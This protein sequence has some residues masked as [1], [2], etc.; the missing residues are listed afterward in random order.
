M[1]LKPYTIT[2]AQTLLS[3]AIAE[4]QPRHRVWRR[5]EHLYATGSDVEPTSTATSAG[6]VKQAPVEINTGVVNQALPHLN[7]IIGQVSDQ[8]PS[9]GATT[10]GYGDG[11]NDEL[12]REVARVAEALADHWF[13]LGGG[14]EALGLAAKDL[15]VLGP[16][17]IKV[18][19]RFSDEE[20]DKDVDEVENDIIALLEASEDLDPD[21]AADRVALTKRVTTEAGVFIEHVSPYDLF[22]DPNAT[23]L[24]DADWVAHRIVKPHDQLLEE[25]ELPADTTLT[26][27]AS[28]TT[29]AGHTSLGTAI[30][31][32]VLMEFAP[33]EVFEFYDLRTFRMTVMQQT[34]PA[35]F[36]GVFPYTAK[37]SP[38]VMKVNYRRD[39]RDL[40]G[41]GDLHNIAGPH[42]MMNFLIAAQMD[43]ASRAGVKVLADSRLVTDEVREALED[44]GHGDVII[45]DSANASL[46]DSVVPIE[47]PPLPA[48]IYNATADMKNQMAETLGLSEL[49]MGKAA[50]A[51]RVAA[52]GIAALEGNTSLRASDKLAKVGEAAAEVGSCILDLCADFQTDAVSLQVA[53][54]NGVKLVKQVTGDTVSG[55][56]FQVTVEAGSTAKV[57]PAVR[58]QK[59][60]QHLTTV[61]PVLR[62]LGYDVDKL[63]RQLARDIGVNPD[64]LVKAAPA[65]PE[66]PAA[67]MPGMP[68]MPDMAGMAGMAGEVPPPAPEDLGIDLAS[69]AQRGGTQL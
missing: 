53:G 8:Y 27:L 19:W 50:A 25:L 7:L 39:A 68:A 52:T 16:M 1:A 17:I 9:F 20:V 3:H 15:V 33:T 21:T 45:V 10:I 38:F 69:D 41:F 30:D 26:P 40:W 2:Q 64:F 54:P 67:G 4:A 31:N 32:A 42:A 51:S 58:E 5:L 37:R 18:G 47:N 23:S 60:A 36:E 44:P 63:V 43:N 14:R 11:H 48:D 13:R 24:A 66:A 61:V 22:I 6:F 49:Q 46:R 62:E 56:A 55:R 65:A 59:A 12:E 28:A 57:N 29:T 35:L 34:G